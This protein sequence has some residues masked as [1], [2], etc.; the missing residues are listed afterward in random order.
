MKSH[1]QQE[2]STFQQR[3]NQTFGANLLKISKRLANVSL[4]TEKIQTHFINFIWKTQKD[5]G[6]LAPFPAFTHFQQSCRRR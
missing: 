6:S 2:S 1:L 4:D 5:S 3:V